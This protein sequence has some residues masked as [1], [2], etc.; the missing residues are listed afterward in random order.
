MTPELIQNVVGAERFVGVHQGHPARLVKAGSASRYLHADEMPELF[1][2]HVTA[3]KGGQPD[4]GLLNNSDVL[5]CLCTLEEQPLE[6]GVQLLQQR[7][8]NEC[9][10]ILAGSHSRWGAVV[11]IVPRV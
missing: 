10:V 1:I 8:Y 3:K 2:K 6:L 5:Y 11:P 7:F 9:H 4:N